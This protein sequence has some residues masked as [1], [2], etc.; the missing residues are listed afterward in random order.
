MALTKE[1]LRALVADQQKDLDLQVFANQLLT[2]NS[3]YRG[4]DGPAME[5]AMRELIEQMNKGETLPMDALN[6][7]AQKVQ[8]TL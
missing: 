6:A 5:T 4:N 8:K 2:A 1:A 3:W 7:A